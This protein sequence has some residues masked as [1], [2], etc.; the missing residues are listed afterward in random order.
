MTQSGSEFRPGSR[1]FAIVLGLYPRALSLAREPPPPSVSVREGA[2]SWR[3]QRFV[4]S[5]GVQ[6]DHEEKSPR[7]GAF[8][9][10]R[11]GSDVNW[12]C[13]FRL[14]RDGSAE[15]TVGHQRLHRSAVYGARSRCASDAPG[16]R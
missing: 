3:W 12:T 8:P 2:R 5:A 9:G 13:K 11:L 10:R 4:G 1:N 15:K 7:N 16:A 14:R 6:R